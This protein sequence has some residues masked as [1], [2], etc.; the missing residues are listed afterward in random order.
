MKLES[1]SSFLRLSTGLLC[2]G[3]ALWFVAAAR[4]ADGP[5]DSPRWYKGNTHA[6]SHWSDGDEFP[7][8][9]ADWYKS[10]G[11]DFLA[12]SDH[13]VLM[14]G[15]RWVPVDRGERFFP[16]LVVE[17]CQKRF[18]ADWLELRAE[19]DDHQVKLKTLDEFRSKLEEPGRFLLIQNEEIDTQVGDHNVHMNAVNLAECIQSKT[20]QTIADTISLNVLMIQEQANRL[21]RPILAQANHPDWPEYDVVAEDLAGA[22]PL[23]F[24]EVCNTGP[25]GRH[26]GDAT[27]PGLEKLWD[28]ANTIRIAKMKEPP[29]YGIA[30]DDA[31]AYQQFTPGHANPGRGFIMVRAKQLSADVLLDAMNRGD[32][33]ASTGVTLRDIAYDAQKRIVSVEVEP[34]ANVAYTIEFIG[35]P[36]GVDPAGEPVPSANGQP[37]K[38]PGRKYSPEV[39]KV[40]ASVQGTS[41]SYQLT[42]KELYVRAVIRSNKPI[43]N[44]PNTSV[45]Q[46]EAWC[47]P[48]G[49]E[50]K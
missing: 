34:E 2:F 19:G 13:R 29:L 17:K 40:F 8:M 16:M 39:G 26:F 20:A 44:A 6:H 35:T 37:E 9:V 10:H 28:I 23:R 18:G 4:A 27:H 33:Y 24:F 7:E 5:G 50:A 30:S 11:Y 25:W 1:R 3:L 43:A 41:A 22:L 45:Q 38:R 48:V 47:Q 14:A 36:E 12:L 42:G 32:F 46:Q 21:G 15:E 49:W 31:H